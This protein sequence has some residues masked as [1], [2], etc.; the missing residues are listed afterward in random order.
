MMRSVSNKQGWRWLF[1]LIALVVLFMA[2]LIVSLLV[3]SNQL[4]AHQFDGHAWLGWRLLI[5][6]L[7]IGLW[8]FLIQHLLNRLKIK[9][10]QKPARLPLVILIVLYELLIVQN[11]LQTLLS[12]GSA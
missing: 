10:R 5:Y 6:C 4:P 12:L 7:L 9:A 2:G 11:P 3:S 1:T 8:P